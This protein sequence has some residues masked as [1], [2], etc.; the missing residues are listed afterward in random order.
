MVSDGEGNRML[1]LEE[2]EYDML[3]R[4]LMTFGTYLHV[5]DELFKRVSQKVTRP[6]NIR[7]VSLFGEA[8]E[9]SQ[10]P[11]SAPEL[12]LQQEPL[13]SY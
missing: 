4:L 3:F 2:D 11:E 12:V 6:F 1:I 10:A 7:D 13:K 8:P 9:P 5:E